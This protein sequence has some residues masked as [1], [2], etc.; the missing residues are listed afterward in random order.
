MRYLNKKTAKCVEMHDFFQYYDNF[1]IVMKHIEK[2][3]DLHDYIVQKRQKFL[4]KDVQKIFKNL[5]FAV[6]ELENLSILHRDI[7]LENIIIDKYTMEIFLID[8]GEA[9]FYQP[10]EV[11]TSYNGTQIYAP[12]EFV[13]FGRYRGDEMTVWQMGHVLY[14]LIYGTFA[15]SNSDEIINKEIYFSCNEKNKEM[16]CI[17]DLLSKCLE[18]N[19]AKRIKL[20]MIMFHDFFKN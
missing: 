12:P 9:C 16:S 2:S 4:F 17:N 15:F 18:K 11:F 20:N 19:F 8:F 13:K 3:C 6:C 10:N 7:K 1:F 5:L 14:W